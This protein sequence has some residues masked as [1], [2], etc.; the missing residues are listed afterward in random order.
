MPNKTLPEGLIQKGNSKMFTKET[1]P[2]ALFHE[3]SLNAERWGL[4]HLHEGR[5]VFVDLATSDEYNLTAPDQIMINPE[6]P[7]KLRLDP[8]YDGPLKFHIDFYRR[9][10][11]S[12]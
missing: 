12:S 1:V 9:E 5:V 4:L 2:D 7:H 11:S 3:H 8:G 10:E 6:V